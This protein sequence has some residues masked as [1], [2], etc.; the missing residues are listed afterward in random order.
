MVEFEIDT[1][2]KRKRDLNLTDAVLDFYYNN[3]EKKYN[4]FCNIYEKAF[5]KIPNLDFKGLIKYPY[6]AQSTSRSGLFSVGILGGDDKDSLFELHISSDDGSNYAVYYFDESGITRE[7]TISGDMDKL[8]NSFNNKKVEIT[9]FI[10]TVLNDAYDKLSE[11]IKRAG[12]KL[13]E[14]LNEAKNDILNPAI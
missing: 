8:L 9:S 11:A 6:I 2:P 1:A 4:R 12:F 3:I 14:S 13:G 10:D 5:E 7:S